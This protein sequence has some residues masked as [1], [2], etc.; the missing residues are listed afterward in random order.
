VSDDRRNVAATAIVMVSTLASRLLGFV[1]IAVIGAVFGASGNADVLNLVFNIPNNLRKLLAEGALSSAF[2]PALSRSH[3]DDPTGGS[4]HKLVRQLIGFQL[5]V[6]LPIIVYSIVAP[7]SVVGVILDFPEVQRQILAA[8]LFRWLILYLLFISVAAV[9][10][11]TLNS[12]GV[13]F[14]PAVAPLWFSVAVIGS[15]LALHRQIGVFSMVFGVL[16]GGIGQLVLQIPA[17]RRRGYSLVPS[18]RFNTATFRKVMRQWLPVVSTASVFAVNQQIALFFASGLSD[19]SGS[20]LTNALV[21]WQLPFGIFAASITTV[22]FPAMSRQHARGDTT[23]L[24]HS[25]EAGLRGILL[26]LVPSGIGLGIL[27]NE[28][29]AVALQ[30]GAFMPEATVRAATVLS[31]YSIGLFSVGAFT[32][33]QRGYY[34]CDN[35]RTPLRVALVTVVLDVGLIIW[36]KETVLGVAGLALANSI[37]FT[38]GLALY[39]APIRRYAPDFSLRRVA[40]ALAPALLGSAAAVLTV[41]VVRGIFALT[42]VPSQWWVQGSSFQN[43]GLLTLEALPAIAAL[44]GVYRLFGL[45]IRSIRRG[46][47]GAAEPN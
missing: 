23:S 16:I 34:A 36:I 45:D 6:L 9:L 2:I 47:T 39:V 7:E 38:V 43:F 10:M 14:V 27:G 31:Y 25:V 1:R 22:I 15:I 35:Y 3:V 33:L 26:L 28:L 44:V 21:F 42:G 30:R 5:A 24:S 11:G 40:R 17:V 20:A 29:I 37:A 12:H 19:G 8:R 41:L 13:L 4:A 46:N 18:F 32:F